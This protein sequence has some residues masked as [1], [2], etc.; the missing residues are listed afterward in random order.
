MKS[1][2]TSSHAQLGIGRAGGNMY[3]LSYHAYFFDMYRIL[4]YEC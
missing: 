4:G 2:P 1:M 3:K